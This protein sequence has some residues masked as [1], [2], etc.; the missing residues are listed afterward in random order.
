M[1]NYWPLNDLPKNHH[2]YLFRPTELVKDAA[3]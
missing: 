1:S 3:F 2:E